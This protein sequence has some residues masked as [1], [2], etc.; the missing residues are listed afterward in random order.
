MFIISPSQEEEDSTHLLFFSQGIAA[1]QRSRYLRY[2]ARPPQEKQ[3]IEAR[4]RQ[5][6]EKKTWGVVRQ[7]AGALLLL[8][9]TA[10][11]AFSKNA[12]IE[13]NLNHVLHNHLTR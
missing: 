6:G 1:R 9:V 8:G 10:V 3:L 4:K 5:L 11:A 2:L 7:A 13:F 12:Q